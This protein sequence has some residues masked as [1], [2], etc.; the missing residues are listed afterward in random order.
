MHKLKQ[1]L[2]LIQNTIYFNNVSTILK[3]TIGHIRISC[4]FLKIQNNGTRTANFFIF[5]KKKKKKKKKKK[6][7]C[8]VMEEPTIICMKSEYILVLKKRI[9]QE[10]IAM[11]TFST[12]HRRPRLLGQ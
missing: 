9:G 6:S 2:F 10:N 1:M 3:L 5:Q 11:L 7:K 8:P 4:D 12:K